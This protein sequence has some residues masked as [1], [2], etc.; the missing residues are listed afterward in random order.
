[1]T[2]PSQFSKQSRNILDISEKSIKTD[3]LHFKEELLKDMK[4]SQKKYYEK[5]YEMD[6]SLKKKL[7]NYDNKISAFET[8]ILEL[9]KL[10][11][12]DKTYR[13]KVDQLYNFKEKTSDTLLTQSIQLKNIE[14]YS[15]SNI[16]NLENLLTSSVLYPGIIG[17]KAKFKNFHAF[18]DYVID[19]ISDLIT[20]KEK[21]N[22]T[23][24]PYKKKLESM[25]EDLKK[26]MNSIIETNKTY[27]KE[28]ITEAEEKMQ[29]L[30]QLY[31]D[32]LQDTRVE[33]AH[34]SIGLEKKAEELSKLIV[35]VENTK[36]ELYNKFD[37]EVKVI[38][39]NYES[40]KVFFYK[41]KKQYI[42]LKDRF[43]QLAEF[44]KDIRFRTNLGEE[45]KR[46]EFLLMANK[47]DFTKKQS[48]DESE[49]K[50]QIENKYN[51][52]KFNYYNFV[53]DI[54]STSIIK[55]YISGELKAEDLF[56]VDHKNYA[57][58]GNENHNNNSNQKLFPNFTKRFQRRKTF[59]EEVNIKNN[60]P[61]KTYKKETPTEIKTK[62]NKYIRRNTVMLNVNKVF[63]NIA[64]N[65]E[66]N[67]IDISKSLNKI[68]IESKVIKEEDEVLS[69]HS[70]KE[71]KEF[72]K[73]KS[74]TIENIN[75][76]K[77]K[78]LET[79]IE[80]N[81]IFKRSKKK[82]NIINS[83]ENN[84]SISSKNQDKDSPNVN[85]KIDILD[86]LSTL[87]N[88]QNTNFQKQTSLNNSITPTVSKSNINFEKTS[89]IRTNI[90][91]VP[92][93]RNN[94]NTI[95][96]T[97]NSNSN[98]SSLRNNLSSNPLKKKENDIIY[99]QN[100]TDYK[101]SNKK[102]EINKNDNLPSINIESKKQF[103]KRDRGTGKDS[104]NK[105]N[106]VNNNNLIQ[107]VSLKNSL[108][109]TKQKRNQI[110]SASNS[111]DN[112]NKNKMGI[113]EYKKKDGK[114][115]IN[116]FNKLIMYLPENNSGINTQ[117]NNI[118]PVSGKNSNSNFI[119]EM[120]KLKK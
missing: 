59:S 24:I 75:K 4:I 26:Q 88:E 54:S 38:K 113:N 98:P 68:S 37:K 64:K 115:I 72:E 35:N 86:G 19:Q 8:K 20:F 70:N 45:I 25:Q 91:P 112:F 7:E 1:M 44:I 106:T 105:F 97:D 94:N 74:L 114:N 40:T 77:E 120:N 42:L 47:I 31:D 17:T 61:T 104:V 39:D 49:K 2:S 12:T 13:E 67:N 9:S 60:L 95:N 43:T 55:R 3:M 100:K 65:E 10:I 71:K 52:E 90:L 96:N 27:T 58:E 69:E 29:S 76:E 84:I 46:K 15:K 109:E 85:K 50:K 80:K 118:K 103:F 11:Q 23:L 51:D 81:L 101:K 56:K 30:I 63:D 102:T 99:I 57:T 93:F 6:D 41:Y 16:S 32:R 34:Y 110:K 117:R 21:T 53:N 82:D 108:S 107:I 73:N 89:N 78:E 36:N 79:E 66:S 14:E 62:N 111:R 48:L 87:P 28:K 83:N 18:I 116:V 33:N 119:G 22:H 5:L 92:I